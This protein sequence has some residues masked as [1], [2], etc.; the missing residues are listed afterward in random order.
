MLISVLSQEFALECRSFQDGLSRGFRTVKAWRT[1]F[2]SMHCVTWQNVER[3]RRRNKGPH[4][5]DILRMTVCAEQMPNDGLEERIHGDS[6][7]E[8]ASVPVA[9]RVLY[10]PSGKPCE[11]SEYD[12]SSKYSI[13]E[14][15]RSGIHGC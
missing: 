2:V 10:S 6:R 3:S 8:G 4:R 12:V 11:H 5:G 7:F 15:E 14:S 13:L 1:R 9:H